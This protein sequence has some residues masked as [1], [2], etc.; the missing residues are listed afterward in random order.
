MRLKLT[1]RS[2]EP[3]TYLPLNYQYPIAAKIYHILSESSPEYSAFLHDNGYIGPDGKLRKLF[4]FSRLHIQ[5]KYG[6][7][8]DMLI[9]RPYHRLTLYI[10]SPMIED[11]VQNLVIGLFQDQAIEIANRKAKGAFRVEQVETCVPPDFTSPMRFKVLSPIVVT[12]ASRD[13]EKKTPH[14]Y[15]PHEDELSEA[16]R[17]SLIKKYE[18]A[19]G[20]PPADSSL[21]FE[22][23]WDYIHRKGGPE[24]T[25]TLVQ[26][27]EGTKEQ[28]NV[29]GFLVPFTLIGSTELM[30]IAW[31]AGMGDKCSMGFGCVGEI[32]IGK[33][34]EVSDL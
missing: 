1:L 10:S 33:T 2:A 20:H 22:P 34:S 24:K 5:P 25:M 13:E 12:K 3:L 26:L 7:H 30:K 29:K 6:R 4:T 17:R 8:G 11:F 27:L 15:R 16:I 31:E 23:D 32:E 21:R 18:T 19:Y 9:L 28:T 14:Y